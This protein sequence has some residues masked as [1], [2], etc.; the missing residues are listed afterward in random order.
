MIHEFSLWVSVL[1]QA[2]DDLENEPLHSAS[3]GEAQAFFTG[4]GSWGESRRTVGDFLQ[5]HPDELKRIGERHLKARLAREQP[6]KRRMTYRM[7]N[8][9]ATQSPRSAQ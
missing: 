6:T 4:A 5:M 1:R 9:V 2:L 8:D 3:F 7:L